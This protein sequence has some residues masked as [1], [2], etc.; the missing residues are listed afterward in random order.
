MKIATVLFDLDGTLLPMDQDLFTKTYFKGLAKKMMPF[1]YD[2][3]QLIASVW[4]GTKAMVTNDGSR[5]CEEA[6]WDK[7]AS[8]LG[9][10]IREKEPVFADFYANEFQS[11]QSVCGCNPEAAKLVRDLKAVGYRVVLATNPLFPAI[12]TESRTRWAGLEP[13]EFELV[14]TYENS[15]FCKPNPAYYQEILEKIGAIPEECIMV[16][17]EVKEDMIPTAKLGMPNFL[18]T[19]CLLNKDGLVIS[20][21]P[22]GGFAQLRAYFGL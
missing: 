16:G 10:D 12:A 14:T 2:P 17:N 22:Q 4:A 15:R 7:F 1:G 11:V 18:L 3:E 5:T 9:E 8:L 6:F 20:A 21:Y 19:D 13:D